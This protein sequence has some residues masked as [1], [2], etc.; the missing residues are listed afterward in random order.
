MTTE[1]SRSFWIEFETTI[2]GGTLPRSGGARVRAASQDLLLEE[3]PTDAEKLC[4]GGLG[5]LELS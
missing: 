4:E 1:S 5:S 3:R 2:P